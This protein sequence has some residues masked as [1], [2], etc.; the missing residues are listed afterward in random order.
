MSLVLCTAVQIA[1]V[2]L[3]SSL[4][5]KPSAVTGHSSGEI[6]AAFAAGVLDLRSA[7]AIAYLRGTVATKDPQQTALKGGMIAVGLGKSEAESYLKKLRSGRVVV[8]C[9]NSPSSVTISG[10]FCAIEELEDLLTSSQVFAR[11]LKVPLAYHSHHMMPF[12]KDYTT[13]LQKTL[14]SPGD[15]GSL[16]YASPVTGERLSSSAQLGHENWVQ[17]MVQPVL[18]LDSFR[19]MCLETIPKSQVMKS[20][21]DIVVEI[22]PHSALA[23]PIRQIMKL[24][25]FGDSRISY[26]SCLIRDRD[27]VETVQDVATFLLTR[28]RCVDLNAVNFPNGKQA[29]RVIADLPSYPWNHAMRHWAEPHANTV[30]RTREHAYH[31]LLGWPALFSNPFTSIWRHFIRA[32][33][34]PWVADHRVQSSII[35]PAAGFISMA[36][37]AARQTTASI[38][39]SVSGFELRDVN[40]LLALVV[41]D[42]P[43]GIEVQ[44]SFRRCSD[45]SLTGQDWQSFEV[46][47]IDHN[48][49]WTRHCKGLITT[50]SS[51]PRE[52]SFSA[53][54]CLRN[55]PPAVDGSIRHRR[56]SRVVDPN[57][58]YQSL[59]SVGIHHGPAFQNIS[60]IEVG[61]DESLTLFK[62]ADTATLMP[63]QYQSDHLL[64]P[65]TLDSIFQSAYSTLPKSGSQKDAMVPKTIKRVFIATGIHRTP[66]HHLASLSRLHSHKA[67]GF[68]GSMVI[69][70]GSPESE[71]PVV[72]VEELYCQSIGNVAA[73]LN[74]ADRKKLCMTLR[75]DLDISRV[76]S[77]HLKSL[78]RQ[79]TAEKETNGINEMR[80][81]VYLFI[82]QALSSLN[83][84]DTKS[85]SKEQKAFYRWMR[86]Q[87]KLGDL[88]LLGHES[89]A[90]GE[91]SKLETQSLL[92]SVRETSVNGEMLCRIGSHLVDILRGK[93]APLEL[94]LQS[95]LLYLYY[96]NDFRM[97]RAY[98]QA[99]IIA[100]L[101]AHK[102][103][104]PKVLEI[105]AGTGGCTTAI[106]QALVEAGTAEV[107]ALE[108][109]DFTDVSAGFF[110]AAREKYAAWGDRIT[111]KVFDVEVD[112][113]PQGFEEGTYD[114]IVACRVLHATTRMSST[115]K[116]V[117]RLLKPGGKLLLVEDTRDALDTQLIFGVLPGWWL[118]MQSLSPCKSEI[119]IR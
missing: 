117:R 14:G 24:P 74:L 95:R 18:F 78:L 52:T 102:V 57:D 86:L 35:Y 4:G 69:Y 27:A 9:V 15:L 119:L 30:H 73:K 34:I 114:L 25:E 62:I 93:I 99:R 91:C 104:R 6:G 96:E 101:L 37:E 42:T 108:S 105:G 64:H 1:L 26:M 70:N 39:H 17:N 66:G 59:Q 65:T 71:L 97:Q 118:S 40:F 11:K 92:N 79:P 75:W 58:L 32:A 36:I 8:A 20:A 51:P 31:D 90:W 50:L 115:M 109:Y 94:M 21:V 49:A 113:I 44:L 43:E 88:D 23:G 89:S 98:V 83:E 12:V 53:A 84:S 7:L 110:E 85:F 80:K 5:I 61:R 48:K 38:N 81:I 41:P 112:P 54:A 67:Q 10:D 47:S 107:P 63:Y 55:T 72:E 77:Q 76:R 29:A 45:A 2:R 19:N 22:G 56:F 60:S 111:Y 87:R 3:L 28:G 13:A 46:L 116:N 106:L 33:E 68:K 103:P 82:R 16:I 100:R